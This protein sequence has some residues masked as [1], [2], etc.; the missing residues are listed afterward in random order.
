MN[1]KIQRR[2]PMII[3]IALAVW[4]AFVLGCIHAAFTERRLVANRWWWVLLGLHSLVLVGIA[5]R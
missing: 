5:K 3:W 4:T 1:A 2:R